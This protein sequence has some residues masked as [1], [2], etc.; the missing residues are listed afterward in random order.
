[1]NAVIL[2]FR[3]T[4]GPHTELESYKAAAKQA[5]SK[6]FGRPLSDELAEKMAIGLR[7]A[8]IRRGATE[9]K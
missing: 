1:M 3:Q 9:A 5:F 7:D 4:Y 6:V 8:S 2:P